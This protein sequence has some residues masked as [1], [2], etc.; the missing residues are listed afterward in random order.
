[1]SLYCRRD[2]CKVSAP[3]TTRLLNPIVFLDIAVGNAEA[4]R[5]CHDTRVGRLTIEL[6][7]DLVPKAAEHFRALCTG[8]A[9]PQRH[10]T[11]RVAEV[12]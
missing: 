5:T 6:R 12:V 7:K 2:T 9:G 3:H 11:P 1:M 10:T 8:E 4:P